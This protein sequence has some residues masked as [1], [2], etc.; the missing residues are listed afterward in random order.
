MKLVC[1]FCN[2]KSDWTGNDTKPQCKILIEYI[3]FKSLL[4]RDQNRLED[5]LPELG[6][7]DFSRFDELTNAG[8]HPLVQLITVPCFEEPGMYPGP[9]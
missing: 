8:D 5:Y 4:F 1:I 9:A 2:S 3:D 7:Y 6:L